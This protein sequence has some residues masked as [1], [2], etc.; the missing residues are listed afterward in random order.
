MNKMSTINKVTI[1][2]STDLSDQKLAFEEKKGQDFSILANQID[3]GSKISFEPSHQVGAAQLTNCDVLIIEDQFEYYWRY[4]ELLNDAPFVK[5]IIVATKPATAVRVLQRMQQ[6]KALDTT[7]LIIFDFDLAADP[8]NPDKKVADAELVYQYLSDHFYQS[9][10]AAWVIG[11]TNYES[12]SGDFESLKETIR[13]NGGFVLHKHILNDIESQRFLI[14]FLKSIPGLFWQGKRK[15][16]KNQVIERI[17]IPQKSSFA[18]SL[19]YLEKIMPLA[20]DV[21]YFE[22][23]NQP[24]GLQF[25]FKLKL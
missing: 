6:T 25:T 15:F 16:Q 14:T 3:L 13:Q 11:L 9:D 21:G 22:M 19:K 24:D 18:E 8:G 1:F 20:G 23:T 12:G 17:E 5:D 4:I 7:D 10:Y 2:C